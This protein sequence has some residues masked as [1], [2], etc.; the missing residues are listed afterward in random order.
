M[1]LAISE[2]VSHKISLANW[3][4]SVQFLH[5]VAQ[6]VRPGTVLSIVL[7]TL[8]SVSLWIYFTA[9]IHHFSTC[10]CVIV[11]RGG[12]LPAKS[13]SVGE[14]F[15]NGDRYDDGVSGSQIRNQP[16]AMDGTVTLDLGWTVLDLCH[17]IFLSNIW[18]TLRNTMVVTKYSTCKLNDL[19][20]GR[21][22]VMVMVP[23]D[24]TLAVSYLTSFESNFV[25]LTVSRYLILKKVKRWKV[26]ETVKNKE[27][28]SL[29]V[30]R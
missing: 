3:L 23:I 17:R 18:N 2:C 1:R 6:D 4:F 9:S 25:S 20:L 29:P 27:N 19:Q 11:C 28:V 22:K 12:Y 13:Q 7:F 10:P 24:S 16:W 30:V 21:F 5:G 15:E 26:G 14:Y 8:D